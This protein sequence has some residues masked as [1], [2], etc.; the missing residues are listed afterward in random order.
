L[1]EARPE[2]PKQL[3]DRAADGW[4]PLMAI[5]DA[6]GGDW[7]ERARAAAIAL[8]GAGETESASLGVLLLNDIRTIFE[9]KKCEAISTT[10]LVKITC[11]DEER[12]WG[13]F[14]EGKGLDARGLARLLKPYGITSKNVRV[15]HQ[16]QAKG[17]ERPDF[18]DSWAR[19]PLSSGESSVP[20]SLGTQDGSRDGSGTD[21]PSQAESYLGAKEAPNPGDAGTDETAGKAP[22]IDEVTL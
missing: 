19:Y 18:V 14:R 4:E 8:N 20:P 2:I 11:A 1:Q 3:D 7:P 12:P 21:E 13:G 22:V 5:A 17:Y 6:A 9:Q 10:D 16:G 15:D